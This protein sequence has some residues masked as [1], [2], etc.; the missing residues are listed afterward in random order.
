MKRI[1]ALSTLPTIE[2]AAWGVLEKGGSALKAALTGFFL[3]AAEDPRVLWSPLVL[4]MGG[5]GT[6]VRVFD[7]RA[8][9]PGSGVKRPRGFLPGEDVPL[10]ARAAVP[11]GI[12]ALAVACAYDSGTSLL[13][14]VRPGVQA[15][16]KLGMSGRATLLDLIASHGAGVLLS[17][18]V[19]RAWLGQ[20][21]P[22]QGGLMGHEDLIPPTEVDQAAARLES[23]WVPP[24][25]A[26]QGTEMGRTHDEHLIVSAD[27]QGQMIALAFRPLEN[28][29][30]LEPFEVA[31]P[32]LAQPVLRGVSRLS[33]GT[34]LGFQPDLWI[35]RNDEG[36]L[37]AVGGSGKQKER[38]PT[39][40]LYRTV[41]TKEIVGRRVESMQDEQAAALPG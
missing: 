23:C 8:R 12:T 19:K 39:L 36:A 22:A 4:L 30:L 31:V 33:P 35:E 11:A 2:D 34:P 26:L 24:F 29:L 9:Q 25:E 20:L 15:A 40:A 41:E 38:T 10:A 17:S 32:L 21:G 7:G 14:C 13:S 1:G 3:A 6:G 37:I 18:R 28:H 5:M 27:S 16:K